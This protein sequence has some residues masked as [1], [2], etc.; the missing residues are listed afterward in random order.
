MKKIATHIL[1]IL[2]FLS[3]DSVYFDSYPQNSELINRKTDDE[4]LVKNIEL[5]KSVIRKDEILE[6]KGEL[7]IPADVEQFNIW[8]MVDNVIIKSKHLNKAEYINSGLTHA[9]RATSV[10]FHD[11]RII[12]SEQEKFTNDLMQFSGSAYYKLGLKLLS[13][14][15]LE[16]TFQIE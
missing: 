15:T 7:D 3:I 4:L 13:K 10:G 16:V 14:A 8:F 11:I 1:Y 2:V 9:W 5:S 6:I 12:V